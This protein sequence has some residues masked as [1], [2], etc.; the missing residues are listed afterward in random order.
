M[1]P[2]PYEGQN[3]YEYRL[4]NKR[5]TSYFFFLVLSVKNKNTKKDNISPGYANP[6]LCTTSL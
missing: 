1:F 5:I 4:T 2:S 3:Y 6:T